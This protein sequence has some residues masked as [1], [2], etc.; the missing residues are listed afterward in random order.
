M[1]IDL[2][3][4]DA[5]AGF[6]EL[7]RF[8][9]LNEMQREA[10][11]VCEDI[12]LDLSLSDFLNQIKEVVGA[13]DPSL[14]IEYCHGYSHSNYYMLV[15]DSVK[16]LD[17]LVQINWQGDGDIETSEKCVFAV[18]FTGNPA[19]VKKSLKNLRDRFPERLARVRWWFMAGDNLNFHDVVLHKPSLVKPEY[20]PFIEKD[21]LEFMHDYLIHN[22]SLLFL[23]GTAG[24]GK[25]TLLRNF[26]FENKLRAVV[27]YEDTLLNSD[28]MFVDFVTSN[29]HDVM[30]IEDA[31]IM[32]GSR[33]HTGNKMI[34]RFLNAS[35]GI[36]QL[37]KK[38]IIFTTNLSNFNDVDEALVRPGR[39]YGAVLFRALTLSEADA[40]AK[41]AGIADWQTPDHDV[42]LAELFNPP[43][44][45]S[46]GKRKIGF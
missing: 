34:A 8:Q 35:D 25:T 44:A 10:L 42:T 22:S 7:I 43:T 12:T 24:T 36:I 2:A 5:Y 41:A 32:L 1:K 6:D 46:F 38:K 28:Q 19:S 21:P 45:S 30:I 11:C 15:Q 3:S 33:E 23:S 39:S 27:T 14:S 4:F 9:F 16:I 37:H 20:Y 26:L 31:D 18:T 40:A 13:A 29:N 17:M